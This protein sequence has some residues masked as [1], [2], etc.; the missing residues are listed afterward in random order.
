MCNIKIFLMGFLAVFMSTGQVSCAQN[1]TNKQTDMKEK[2][3]LVAFFS[4]ADENYNVGYIKK[5]NT[6]I[7]AE[8]IGEATNGKLFHIEPVK[9]YPANYNAC[10]DQ[11]QKEQNTN[12]RPA[13]KDDIAVED[14]D[15]IFLGYPNWW[16]DLPMAVYTFIE[17]HN[18][19]G[20]TVIPFCTHEGS[21]LGNT[22]NRVSKACKGASFLNGLAVQGTSAQNQQSQVKNTVTNWLGKIGF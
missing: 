15:I 3:I 1:K 10:I 12:A 9:A 5:G 14:Y 20:K 7:V 22:P 19:Q 13:I 2:K 8:M 17:K 4:R 11:A 18:W 21:G 16:G 6:Q